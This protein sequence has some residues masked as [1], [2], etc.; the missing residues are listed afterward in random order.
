MKK[1]LKSISGQGMSEYLILVV[2]I[3]VGAIAAT[4][5]VQNQVRKKMNTISEKMRTDVTFGE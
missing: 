4:S 3:A 5:K 2:M 1:Y